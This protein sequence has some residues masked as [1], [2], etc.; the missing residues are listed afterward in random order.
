MSQLKIALGQYSDKGRKE[1][2]QDFHGAYI[3]KEPQLNS[4]GIAVA[5]A[6]GISSSEVSHIASQ[7]AVT[8]F[9][10]D[11]Y[12][13]SEAWSVK[14]SA[15]RV[16]AA[17][18]SWLHSQTHNSPYRFDKDRGYVCTFSTIV[19]KSMTAH[20]FHAGDTRIYQLHG[21]SL[22]QL[23]NDHRVI[24][25]SEEN[26]L[27]RALGMNTQLEVDY[28]TLQVE[29]GDI[30]LLATDGVYE[31]VDATF[32][33]TTINAHK[34]NL[35]QAAKIIVEAAYKH[36]SEDNLT[37]QIVRIDDLPDPEANEIHHQLSQL[38]FPPILEARMDFDGYKIIRE[39]H[40]SSRSHIYLATD[41]ETEEVVIIKTPSVD[42]REN[43]EH[44]ERFLME[45]WVAR[46]IDNAH[47][48]KPCSQTR[49]RNYVYVVTEHIEGKTLTQ[50]MIDN[51]KPN[52]EAVRTIIDQIAKGLRAFHRLEMLHQDLKPGNIM[53]DTTDTVKIIDFGSTRVAGIMESH[54]DVEQNHIVGDAPYV[55]PEYFLGESGTPES[56]IFS[57]GLIAYQMLTGRLPYGTQ[58]PRI[59]NQNDQ[60]RLQYVSANNFTE[61]P[62][63]VDEAIK[64]A[65]H[66]NPLKRYQDVFEFVY[67]L[68]NPNK[69]FLS[70]KHV[71]L[72]ERDPVIF[73]KTVSLVL[74][75]I[76]V[77]L[78][79]KLH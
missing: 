59:K 39:V 64:K 26:Y 75:V 15:E 4:K 24:I 71:P 14:T 20:I 43:A 22:E 6:D 44:L 32:I 31:H 12:S 79:T 61:I 67:D 46:R 33:A 29:K 76:V 47:V 40:G 3:P 74:A 68:H 11:Y 9:L 42:M 77:F 16:L 13:T 57:L 5:I 53:I 69:E 45:E 65:V 34:G 38:S 55:A 18:N 1:T 56:D 70:V 78:L 30:F 36:G 27:G 21:N 48:L 41:S 37:L 25:S 2:N 28:R 7:F 51:P 50:W 66:P 60:K 23:T 8:S 52:I 62:V 73:W 17:T 19:I 49:K 63:W 54:I 10:E 72:I 58:V 35:D